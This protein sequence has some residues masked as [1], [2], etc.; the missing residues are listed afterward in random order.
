[1]CI[2]DRPW[3]EAWKKTHYLSL[4]EPLLS[5]KQS[6]IPLIS[7]VAH[8]TFDLFWIGFLPVLSPISNL[9]VRYRLTFSEKRT[10]P[11]LPL[12]RAHPILRREFVL[13]TVRPVEDLLLVNFWF[14]MEE[15][16]WAQFFRTLSYSL[17]QGT[18]TSM[19]DHQFQRRLY[20]L[21]TFLGDEGLLFLCWWRIHFPPLMIYLCNPGAVCTKIA[22]G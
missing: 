4:G 20:L 22:K 5:L 13:L 21:D 18:Q 7:G 2:R 17:L 10:P 8:L 16:F 12:L 9:V 14:S 15:N 1:M 6:F 3:S 19:A 11:V